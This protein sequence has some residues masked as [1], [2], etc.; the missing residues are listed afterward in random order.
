MRWRHTFQTRIAGVLALLLLVVVAA[1]YFFVKTATARAVENQ[2]QVQ[3]KT[4]SQVFERL[5]D[6]RGRRLQYGLDW[7]T[8]DLPF[9][10]AVADGKTV[11]ILAALRRHGT[12]I[13]SSEVFVLGLDG[14]VMVSTLPIFTRGQFFPYD[15]ALRH[16]RR[17]G[18][19]MLIVAMDGR[20][21]L[22]V[23]DE[24]IDELPIARIVMGFPMD[25]LFANELRSMSNLEV[26]FLSVQD[27]QP[28]PLFSTQPDAYQAGTLSLLREG[29]VDPEPQIHLFYGQ[30]VLSQVLPLANTGDGDEVRVLLQSPLDHALESFAPLDRQFLGIALAVLVVSLA[31]ALFLA[32]RVSRPLNALVQAAER[33]GAGDYRT[34][35]RVRS[36]DEFGLLARA[37][38]AMQSGI[39]VRERQLAHNALHDPLTGLPNRALAMERLGSAI[40]AGRPVVL[41]YVGIENYRLINEGF[42]PEGV[43]EMLREASRCLAMSL[44]AS[45]TAARIAGS[46]FLLL[47]ENTEVDRAVARADRLY[48]LLTEPQRIGNDEL[49]HEVSIGIAA[50]PA[51]GQQ[52]EE[53]ISRAA[54]ARHDAASLPGHLQIYQQDRDLAHQR[55][56]TLIRDL[57]R[58]AIEGELF[59]CYQPKL[60]LKHGHVR[61]AEALLRWQH[62]TLGQVSPAEFIPLA[63]RTGSMSSLTLWV[64][65]EAVRQIAEWAQRGLL[66]QLSVNISVDDLA[67]DDLAIRVTALLMQYQVDAE[68]LIFEITESAIMHNPQQALSVLEQLRGCGICLSVDDFGTGYSSLAQL[69]RLPVQELKIDQSFIRNLNGTSGDGVIVRSTIE[70]SHNLGLKVVAEGVEFAPSLKLLKQWN[71]DTAQGY[72]ISRPLN[73]MAFEMWMRRERVPI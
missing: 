24:V 59:L 73:A 51:D 31:G 72:L 50:Y 35:V 38:N 5:L 68:Q 41:L 21:Y 16:A 54:I 66:I 52:V 27:G 69:Q 19:Q 65:E 20:P 60:D 49:R 48:A 61:Q 44:L 23:Q 22:L 3:L 32:R 62:P 2:A 13:R 29:H 37:F 56:I 64:I 7:L 46:E 45:D 39:A 14:K 1:T 58:A 43:E 47:L 10:Q 30:R 57:R 26:S 4:G 42:G 17:T 40:S 33:I 18:L 11:P 53:L 8:V 12:G 67:D 63:E 6:L 15:D 25:K 36:H 28:G 71:C 70:M 9:K 55:Q 34:P